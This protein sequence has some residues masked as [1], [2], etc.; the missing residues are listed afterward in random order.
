M[1]RLPLTVLALWI[2][3]GAGATAPAAIVSTTAGPPALDGIMGTPLFVVPDDGLPLGTVYGSPGGIPLP[4]PIGPMGFLPGHD[5][6]APG[7]YHA[8]PAAGP[9]AG[10]DVVPPAG[11][12]AIDFFIEALPGASPSFEITAVGTSTVSAPVIVAAP[13]GAPAY[14]GFGAFGESLLTVSIVRLP[15]PSPSSITWDISSL[16]V[17]PEPAGLI[18]LFTASLA[19]AAL[20]P[21]RQPEAQTG[22]SHG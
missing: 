4:T 5:K 9:I 7:V 8:L 19:C 3:V 21:R 13:P 20:R 1:S 14:I 16:R 10:S 2:G 12:S 22:R 17:L 11:A 6:V 15:F 18:V